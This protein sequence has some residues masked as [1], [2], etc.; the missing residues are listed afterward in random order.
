[1]GAVVGGA[2]TSIGREV[3]W[4]SA[5]RGQESVRRAEANGLTDYGTVAALAEACDVILSIC[6]PHAA[7]AVAESVAGFDGTF[8][9]ANAI[10]PQT[11]RAIAALVEG[12]GTRYVDGSIIGPPPVKPGI[13]RLYL[14]GAGAEEVAARF[15][16]SRTEARVL[17]HDIPDA[18]ALKMTY[19]AWTKGT[20]ALVLAIRSL[21]RAEGVEEHL[22]AEWELSMPHLGDYSRAGARQAAE[23]GWRWVGEMEEIAATFGGAGLPDGFH[24]AAADIY[25]RL[26]RPDG[27]TTDGPGL[28]DDVLAHLAGARTT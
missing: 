17:S 1:M 15:L 13:N 26:P 3:G 22:L 7:T 11:S 24:L 14:A 28:L 25:R 4:A 21:A 19:A 16:G 10:A 9:E 8:V 18:S 2:L 23:K 27:Q 6:P 5:G 20:W 12:A